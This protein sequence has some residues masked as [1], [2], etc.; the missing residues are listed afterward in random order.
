MNSKENQLKLNLS[1][2]EKD[3]CL[4]KMREIIFGQYTEEPGDGFF[5]AGT[6]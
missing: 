1:E 5:K 2:E 3:S 6:L 4:N